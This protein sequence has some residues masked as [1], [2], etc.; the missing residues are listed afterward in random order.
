VIRPIPDKAAA[1]VAL[2]LYK[3]FCEF[4]FVEAIIHDQG[5]EFYGKV[6]SISKY[7]FRSMPHFVSYLESQNV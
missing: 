6:R 7:T 2:E 5:K 3:I 1:T 4:G